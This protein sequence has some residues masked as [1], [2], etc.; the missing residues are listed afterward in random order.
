M[1]VV[2]LAAAA[3]ACRDDLMLR[4][5]LVIQDKLEPV[6]TTTFYTQNRIRHPNTKVLFWF[7]SSDDVSISLVSRLTFSHNYGPKGQK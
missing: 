5:N 4:L 1:A 6:R 7:L 3:A 2:G